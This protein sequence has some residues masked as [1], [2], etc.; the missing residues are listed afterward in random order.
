MTQV[1]RATLWDLRFCTCSR[2]QLS[3]I[4]IQFFIFI[5]QNTGPTSTHFQPPGLRQD[6]DLLRFGADGLRHRF[7]VAPA[8]HAL[9]SLGRLRR[10][11]GRVGRWPGGMWH[12]AMECP[13]EDRSVH[14]QDQWFLFYSGQIYVYNSSVIIIIILI[15][16]IIII[17]NALVSFLW[18]YVC[19]CNY[20]CYNLI[21]CIDGH[22][23]ILRDPCVPIGDPKRFSSRPLWEC[24]RV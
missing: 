17:V 3:P 19:Y 8:G 15:I 12:E 5:Y 2:L 4:S 13:K 21:R 14:L 18:H 9:D 11:L 10:L 23:P 6:L 24:Q 7:G 20:W 16:S 1:S 22:L